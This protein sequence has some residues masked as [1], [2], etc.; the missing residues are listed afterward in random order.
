MIDE[1][2]NKYKAM[3]MYNDIKARKRA[4]AAAEIKKN[5]DDYERYLVDIK[6]RHRGMGRR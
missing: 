5:S 3:Q 6:K 1:H 2:S 4:V